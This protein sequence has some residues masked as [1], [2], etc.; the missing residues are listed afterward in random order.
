MDGMPMSK[1]QQRIGAAL[2][3]AVTC[4]AALAIAACSE[5]ADPAP[6]P[7]PAP[8]APAV[9]V[10]P[11]VADKITAG[12]FLEPG[13]SSRTDQQPLRAVS[14]AGLDALKLYE[15]EV[16]CEPLTEASMHCPYDDSSD[17][18]TIG[19]GHLIAKAAC[20]TLIPELTEAGYLDGIS[21]TEAEDLLRR[22]LASSQLSLERQITAVEGDLSK[23]VVGKVGLTETQYDALVSFIF[24]V[25]GG[26]FTSSTLLRVLKDREAVADSAEIARQFTRWTKSAGNHVQGL[27][28]RRNHEVDQFFAGFERP[29]TK[30]TLNAARDA[31]AADDGVDIRVGEEVAQ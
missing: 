29:E 26:G 4:I 14:Q 20:A 30:R 19:H 7:P 5:A 24:N 28:N 1:K 21:K 12:A 10:F 31:G 16:F 6:A 27:L 17:F 9:H 11:K 3:G 8:E 18:C 2:R 23:G 15:G 13:F 25:G 22:D